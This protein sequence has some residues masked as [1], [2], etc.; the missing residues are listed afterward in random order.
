MAGSLGSK[1][2]GPAPPVGSDT[3]ANR[4][5]PRGPPGRRREGRPGGWS[6]R[7]TGMVSGGRDS[8]PR[9]WRRA[10]HWIAVFQGIRLDYIS[11][12]VTTLG[13]SPRSTASRI[14]AIFRSLLNE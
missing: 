3:T 7:E 1:A 6:R 2:S 4:A 10:N 11:H 13:F 12:A 5:L 8:G 9:I 14:S